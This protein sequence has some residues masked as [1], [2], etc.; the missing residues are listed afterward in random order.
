MRKEKEEVVIKADNVNVRIL[1]LSEGEEA[2]WHYHTEIID[3]MF[4]LEGRIRISL[5]EPEETVILLPG[6]R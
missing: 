1:E 4:C 5:K 3:N 2:P 6:Q